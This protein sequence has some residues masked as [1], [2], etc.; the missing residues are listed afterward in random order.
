[1]GLFQHPHVVYNIGHT[2][3][4]MIKWEYVNLVQLCLVLRCHASFEDRSVYLNF[5]FIIT[6]GSYLF[7]LVE[8]CLQR[9]WSSWYFDHEIWVLGKYSACA[10]LLEV[11]WVFLMAELMYNCLS[12]RMTMRDWSM[13]KH[14]THAQGLFHAAIEAYALA[15]LKA[16]RTRRPRYEW[17]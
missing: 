4:V 6:D 12:K 14:H 3:W 10:C 15:G 11:S 7:D 5:V 9:P 16:R 17:A 8:F 1:M 13:L 2:F